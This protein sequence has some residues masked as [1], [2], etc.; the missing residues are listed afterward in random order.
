M[1]SINIDDYSSQIHVDTHGNLYLEFEG[2]LF[3]LNVDQN[4]APYF[5]IGDYNIISDPDEQPKIQT[6]KIVK[7]EKFFN[8]QYFPENSGHD[9]VDENP[10]LYS[11]DE[12]DDDDDCNEED[13]Q[14]TVA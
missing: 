9:L 1:V 6:G 4:N 3:Q 11:D 2:T 10:N 12:Q 13:E 8:D 7:S 14:M 5:D